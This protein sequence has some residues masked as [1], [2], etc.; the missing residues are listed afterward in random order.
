MSVTVE[1]IRERGY[2]STKNPHYSKIILKTK[3]IKNL[4]NYSNSIQIFNTFSYMTLK[5]NDGNGR[6]PVQHLEKIR[7]KQAFCTE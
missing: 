4:R 3:I 2:L 6:V 1:Y 7:I 5:L